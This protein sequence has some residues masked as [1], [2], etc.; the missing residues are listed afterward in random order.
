MLP[1]AD[2]LFRSNSSCEL[3]ERPSRASLYSGLFV[4]PFLHTACEQ[5]SLDALLALGDSSRKASATL[6]LLVRLADLAAAEDPL[7][8]TAVGRLAPQVDPGLQFLSSQS[9]TTFIRVSCPAPLKPSSVHLPQDIALSHVTIIAVGRING[10]GSAKGSLV[11]TFI[12]T[13][14][15][16][17]SLSGGPGKDRAPICRVRWCKL[18]RHK[19][20]MASSFCSRPV[21]KLSPFNPNRKIFEARK[22]ETAAL[23]AGEKLVLGHP[24]AATIGDSARCMQN[25]GKGAIHGAKDLRH[26]DVYLRLGLT[27]TSSSP[28]SSRAKSGLPQTT[29]TSCVSWLYVADFPS[30]LLSLA[31]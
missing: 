8:D 29:V 25:L 5:T 14:E 20:A 27:S 3:I 4:R 31:A 30:R 26:G 7:S 15:R 9:V 17:D 22:R 23:G 19:S 1:A 28:Y 12:F 24:L 13:V 16:I 11:Q 18:P 10:F 6:E 21:P 2:S